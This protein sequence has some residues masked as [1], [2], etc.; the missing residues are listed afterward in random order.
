MVHRLKLHFTASY[1][2]DWNGWKARTRTCVSVTLSSLAISERSEE[3]RYF[4]ISN[5]FSSSKICLPVKVVRAF[6][7]FDLSEEEPTL[8]LPL[9]L[10]LSLST[11]ILTLTPSITRLALLSVRWSEGA[12]MAEAEELLALLVSPNSVV[13]ADTADTEELD[14]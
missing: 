10:P 14:P 6:F 7:F 5:C 9:A 3:E 12:D 1:Q 4:L 8:P 2:I 11:L 13:A